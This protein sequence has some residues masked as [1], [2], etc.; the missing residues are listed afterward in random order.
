VQWKAWVRLLLVFFLTADLFGNMGFFG[1]ELT[2]DYFRKTRILE[3]ISADSGHFRTFATGKTASLDE[4]ILIAETR[5]LDIFKEKHLPSMDLLHRIHNLWGIEV[6]GLKR[7]EDLYKAFTGAPSISATHLIDLYGVKYVISVT[8]LEDPRYD[9]V[10][11]RLEGLQGPREELLKRNTVKLYR[12]RDPFPRAWLV[13]EYRVMEGRA[14]LAAVISK[15]FLPGREVL[16]EEEPEWEKDGV[17][18]AHPQSGPASPSHQVEI[19]SE[20]NNRLD[21]RVITP[22]DAL[23]V[24]SDTYYPGWKA[25]I[26]P[27]GSG[28]S[29]REMKAGEKGILRAN[30]HFRALPLNAGGYEIRFSYEPMSFKLGGLV[31]LFTIMG[32][33][34]YLLKSRRRKG[35]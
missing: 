18:A 34:G 32:I 23:L 4:P 12:V 9:L 27:L 20:S 29:P 26:A 8:P 28:A 11:A 35:P 30:Y 24:V 17:S 22:E 5:F 6:L 31:S 15:E 25:R 33:G 10:Y 16:L 14:T 1:R 7:G 2:A 13:K 21:I 19:L 3:I